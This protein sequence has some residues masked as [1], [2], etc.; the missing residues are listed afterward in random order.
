MGGRRYTRDE[1][2][3]KFKE[4]EDIRFFYKKKFLNNSGKTKDTDEYYS[5]I[6]AE[7]IFE[8]LER[9]KQIPSI[10]RKSSYYR[11]THDGKDQPDSNSEKNIAKRIFQQGKQ[12]GIPGIGIILDYE[13]PLND[14]REN[15]AGSIDLLAFDEDRVILRILELKQPDNEKETMV[16]CV[17]EAYSYNKLVDR[18]KLIQDFNRDGNFN[19]PEGTPIVA[20]PLVFRNSV[21]HKELQEMQ[22]GLRKHLKKLIEQL[23][24]RP[25]II[26]ENETIYSAY[27]LEL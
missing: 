16:R 25:M 14:E 13:T 17:L 20:C 3:A 12:E 10:Q 2:R 4:V 9:F 22:E 8:H 24:V 7:W 6:A 1:Q 11:D 26:E 5:E 21:Q 27:E 23:E 18:E 19:I 15:S